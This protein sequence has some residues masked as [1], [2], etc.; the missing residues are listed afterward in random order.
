MAT[1]HQ[2]PVAKLSDWTHRAYS[3]IDASDAVLFTSFFT[4]DVYF[5]F[6]NAPPALGRQAACD[7]LAA[8]CSTVR[9]LKHSFIGEWRVQTGPTTAA[10][11]LESFVTYTR[12]SGEVVQP[13]PALT[14]L[15]LRVDDDGQERAEWIQIYVDLAPLLNPTVTNGSAAV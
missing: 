11:L 8:F 3:A 4:D 6:A 5:A 7:A 10:L 13:I 2:Q 12:H 1:R 14:S 15:R 9:S